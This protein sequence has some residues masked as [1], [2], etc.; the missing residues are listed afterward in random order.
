VEGEEGDPNPLLEALT[1]PLSIRAHDLFD[2]KN[3]GGGCPVIALFGATLLVECTVQSFQKVKSLIL[4]LMSCKKIVCSTMM[5]IDPKIKTCSRA[6]NL[7]Y[8]YLSH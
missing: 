8:F 6:M 5:S 4:N 1:L 2:C 3:V 7:V